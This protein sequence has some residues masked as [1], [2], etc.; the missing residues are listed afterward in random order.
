MRWLRSER[1]GFALDLLIFLALGI[2]GEVIANSWWAAACTLILVAGLR[3]V[4][5]PLRNWMTQVAFLALIGLGVAMT[6]GWLGEKYPALWVS[7]QWTPPLMV[8][9][10]ALPS[11]VRSV[12]FRLALQFIALALACLAQPELSTGL[13]LLIWF[14]SLPLCLMVLFLESKGQ[15]L[16]FGRLYAIWFRMVGI[17]IIMA[18]LIFPF[19]PRFDTSQYYS[20]TT[21]YSESVSADS[22]QGE[23]AKA[24]TDWWLVGDAGLEQMRLLR[25]R[26]LDQWVGDTLQAGGLKQGAGSIVEGSEIALSLVAARARTTQTLPMPYGWAP[27]G[28]LPSPNSEYSAQRF[29]K[30][31]TLVPKDLA[32]P[33]PAPQDL[34]VPLMLRSDRILRLSKT[35]STPQA[36][37]QFFRT[38]DFTPS[39]STPSKS[40]EEFLF[41]DRKGHCQYFALSS[42]VLLRLAGIPTRMIS[43][44][45]VSRPPFAGVLSIRSADAH[46][47]LEVWNDQKQSWYP[48][49]P[50][51]IQSMNLGWWG[52]FSLYVTD[53]SDTAYALW[54][55]YVVGFDQQQWIQNLIR[56]K[57]AIQKTSFGVFLSFA[58]AFLLVLLYR[59]RARRSPYASWIR[60]Y[61][62]KVRVQGEGSWSRRWMCTYQ[63][64]RFGRKRSPQLERYQNL[65]LKGLLK[66]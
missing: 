39:L 29:S 41:R 64:L 50:T 8:L 15:H 18:A 23:N 38:G 40:V 6:R 10:H 44:Y 9:G 63:R 45:R 52:K 21:G 25:A 37:S 62:K 22:S 31:F 7:L 43:G 16:G 13:L 60:K 19:L 20:R 53:L 58:A 46:A 61:E 34:F 2:S 66:S 56:E 55:K 27:V 57:S 4:R 1:Y 3:A 36:V 35:L 54:S 33:P 17:L 26:V 32:S 28:H 65:R 14:F 11:S 30:T 59:S 47:W 12:G 42:L 24:I 49:D 51:P 5:D 48:F